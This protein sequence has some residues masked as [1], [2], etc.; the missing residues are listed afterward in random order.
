L[1]FPLRGPALPS[2]RWN[3]GMFVGMIY[4]TDGRGRKNQAARSQ[5]A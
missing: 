5:A 2:K 1:I 4:A 3:E